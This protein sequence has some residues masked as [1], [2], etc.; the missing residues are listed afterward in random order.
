MPSIIF[1]YWHSLEG[2][3]TTLLTVTLGVCMADKKGGPQAVITRLYSSNLLYFL[4]PFLLPLQYLA[5]RSGHQSPIRGCI[6][7]LEIISH[8]CKSN[9]LNTFMRIDMLNQPSD[10]LAMRRHRTRVTHRSCLRLSDQIPQSLCKSMLYGN[11]G[12]FTLI[13]TFQPSFSHMA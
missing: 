6:L 8:L 4:L 3:S 12:F 10:T 2:A 11:E 5:W 1:T 9:P 7:T 13:W